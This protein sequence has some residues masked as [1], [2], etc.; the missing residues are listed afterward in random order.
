MKTDGGLSV[1]IIK[2]LIYGAIAGVI[3]FLWSLLKLSAVTGGAMGGAIGFLAIIWMVVG[4][5]IGLF[6][7]AVII[8]VLSAICGG[9][10]DFE[11][12]VR[13]SAALMVL[14]PV[15]AFFRFT[16]AISPSLRSIILL[17]VFL[18]GLWMLYNVLTQTLKAKENSVKIISIVLAAII[19]LFILIGLTVKKK[20][21]GFMNNYGT[22]SLEEFGKEMEK[23]GK[24]YEKALKDLEEKLK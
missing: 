17:L 4:A 5:L 22:E 16:G 15:N 21:R 18:Y 7:G 6:I 2:A 8:L 20:A 9:K 24:D 11:P 23:Y 1:P 13:A 3:V 10:T 19:V 14:M 12:A